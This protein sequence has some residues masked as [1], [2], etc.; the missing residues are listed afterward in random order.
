M[1]P[2]PLLD[3]DAAPEERLGVFFSAIADCKDKGY[4]THSLHPYPAK[5]IPH[6]PREVIKAYSIPGE[7]VWD[8]MCGSGTTLV[9]AAL[10]GRPARGGDLNPIAVLVSKAK[11]TPLGTA[12]AAELHGLVA[13]LELAC[14]RAESLG[15]EL[16]DFHNR[17][18]WFD[19]QVSR[20]LAY[21]LTEIDSLRTPAAATLARCAFSAIVVAV[22]NQESETRWSA[23]PQKV[24]PS[25]TLRRLAKK[26]VDSIQRVAEFAEHSE[27]EVRIVE[28]DA[29]RSGAEDESVS[30]VVTSPP[31]A[32]S[33]DYYLYNKL[34]MFW[35]GHEV[36]PVQDAE[37][38]SRN[39][40]SDRGLGVEG[41]L[42]PMT[43]VLGQM[44]RALVPGGRAVLVVADAVIRKQFFSMDE[45]LI[46]RA[47]TAGL[48]Y[49]RKFSF[50]H[51]PFNSSFQRGFGTSRKKSTHVLVFQ[52]P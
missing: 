38:G 44:H 36:R 25:Q 31:Y 17:D 46:E 47:E 28:E 8:P 52:R 14:G 6:I 16:P 4:A 29:R 2:V 9:E 15:S 33:H 30:L 22:S 10:A 18:H 7:T 26:I 48:A 51:K 45:L 12:A 13:E 42:D 39:Q 3:A 37:I 21:A 50:D 1:S 41:Y 20:E 43:E 23:K 27:A 5:F 40:H 49:D 32:N 35:L 24:V 34:R 11:T 19:Q